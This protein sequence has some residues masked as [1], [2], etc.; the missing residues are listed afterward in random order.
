MTFIS[1]NQWRCFLK[2]D[3]FNVIDGQG[4]ILWS[5][6]DNLNFIILT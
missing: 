3:L 1:L 2:L 5:G 4:T 6:L